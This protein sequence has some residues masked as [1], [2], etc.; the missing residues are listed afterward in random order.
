MSE[1][2]SLAD[3][4][5]SARRRKRLDPLNPDGKKKEVSGKETRKC[6]NCQEVGHIAVNCKKTQS[7]ET[8]GEEQRP[9]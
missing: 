5:V 8:D 1:A 2:G 7:A 3:D 4:Y 9:D 6:H